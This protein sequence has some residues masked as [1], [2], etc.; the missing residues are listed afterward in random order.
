MSSARLDA[1][2]ADL[3]SVVRGHHNGVLTFLLLCGAGLEEAGAAVRV[4]YAEANE[5]VVRDQK[6]WK[7]LPDPGLWLRKA[8]FNAWRYPL[9][10]VPR[11]VA[12]SVPA[13]MPAG[14]ELAEVIGPALTVAVAG[15][16]G[17]QRVAM[18]LELGGYRPEE[19]GEFLG[20]R[21]G[22]VDDLMAKAWAA[23][24]DGWA[25]YRAPGGEM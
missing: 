2:H 11:G 12:A 8:A 25:A 24:K 3:V 7:K 16:H 10:S 22:E 19:I 5:L 13:V 20:L 6:A 23:L 14:I 4:A 15:L 1:A 18:A 21:A 9:G 17:A